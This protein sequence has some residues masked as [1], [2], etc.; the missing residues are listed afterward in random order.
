MEFKKGDRVRFL[1]EV[2]GGVISKL[3]SRNMVYV[4]IEEGFEI[5]VLANELIKIDP[6]TAAE[7][8]FDKEIHVELPFE[9]EP[10]NKEPE[11]NSSKLSNYSTP[12]KFEKGIYLAFAPHDQ[13]WL[14][15]GMID[16]YYINNTSYD[17]LY[18]IL[19]KTNALVYG[20]DYGNA[21]PY[22]KVLI[23]TINREELENWS[24]GYVQVVFHPNNTA[25]AL[26]PMHSEFSIKMTRMNDQESYIHSSFISEKSIIVDLGMGLPMVLEAQK[27]T[28]RSTVSKEIPKDYFIDKHLIDNQIAEVD[29]HIEKL[30]EGN[31][32]NDNGEILKLQFDYY[33][34][35]IE[36]A[37]EKR[38]KKVIF[39]HGVGSG[40]LKSLIRGDLKQFANITFSEAPYEKYG[41]GALEVKIGQ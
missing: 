2:G 29:L 28:P 10:L 11:V 35:C 15:T 22:S 19:L 26:M 30:C 12:K 23:Q 9:N 32:P 3:G 39:I 1:N 34:R 24:R 40:V 18:S 38:L 14:L 36:S 37:L 27:E 8:M 13:K 25:R 7:R 41:Y 20:A 21:E 5:P 16:L 33:T 4:M 17:V 31:K 6:V